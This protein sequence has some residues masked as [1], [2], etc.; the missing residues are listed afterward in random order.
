M[1]INEGPTALV[2][3]GQ[4]HI[5]YSGSGYWVQEYALGRLTYDGTGSLLSASNWVKAP[6]PVFQK[7]AAVVGVGHA[8]FTK[9]PDGSQ[10]WIVYH[11]HPSPGGDPDQRVI[12]VQ[13]Y[14]FNADGTPNFG[15]PLASGT[16][17]E[18]P[19]GTADL[20]RPFLAGDYDAN[21]ATG[22]TDLA[23]FTGQLGLAA[24]PGT[25]ADGSGDGF[26]DGADFLL[27]QRQFG[28]T[29]SAAMAA[30]HAAAS[31][32][33]AA[34]APTLAAARENV[35]PTFQIP[36]APSASLR[37]RVGTAR[38]PEWRPAML[39]AAP[40]LAH[41][42]P[43]EPRGAEKLHSPAV[44]VAPVDGEAG[45]FA[46]NSLAVDAALEMLFSSGF[47]GG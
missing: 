1:P 2:H 4:L 26:A 37:T 43:I 13:P 45:R 41:S 32:L 12:H 16:P 8:S 28:A 11:S 39:N 30:E 7:T 27:W 31:S 33:S 36:T 23:V 44:H 3:D 24:F 40:Q 47:S 14:T 6:G 42:L 15:S 46:G 22:A 35:V 34:A 18:T 29:A 9:S 5:I 17:I 19:R 21:G 25:G 10:D 20:E 38:R